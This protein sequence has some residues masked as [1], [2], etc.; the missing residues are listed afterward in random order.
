MESTTYSLAVMQKPQQTRIFSDSKPNLRQVREQINTLSFDPIARLGLRIAFLNLGLNVLLLV[1]V[2][3]QLPPE[4]PL[5]Y[6][7]P[8]GQT[9][10]VV[11]W[12]LWLLPIL[13]L[14][15]NI[16]CLRIAAV[17]LTTEKLLAQILIWVG[18]LTSLMA[19]VTL[20]KIIFLVT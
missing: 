11:T 5:L 7:Y 8:Y 10:L 14:I 13:T 17:V 3:R 2:W 9:Q 15:I 20:V 18:S 6:S 12:G 19:T 4:V 16:V 1:L